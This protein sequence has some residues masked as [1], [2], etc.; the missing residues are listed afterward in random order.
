MGG[1]DWMNEG[2]EYFFKWRPAPTQQELE[3]H[4]KDL[5]GASEIRPVKMQGSLSY[6]VIA[7]VTTETIVSFRVP[8]QKLGGDIDKLARKIHG[9]VVPEATYHGDVGSTE[10]ASTGLLTVCTMPYLPGKSYLEVMSPWPDLDES[11][12][13]KQLNFNR[14][15]ARYF[16]RAWLNPQPVSASKLQEQQDFVLKKLALLEQHS[17]FDYMKPLLARLRGKDGVAKL[18]S[19]TH[20]QVL[21]HKD[22]NPQNLLMDPEDFSITGLIDWSRARIA[23]F[24]ID[25]YAVR[26][27]NGNVNERGWTD[28]KARKALEA[29]FWDEFFATTLVK[30]ST[31]QKAIQATAEM[32]AKLSLILDY[33]FFTTLGGDPIDEV[34]PCPAEYLE[35]WLGADSWHDIILWDE[36]MKTTEKEQEKEKQKKATQG[37]AHADGGEGSDRA[38][39]KTAEEIGNKR[40]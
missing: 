19:S 29:A 3:K 31:E 16:A 22:L 13:K 8:E 6:T 10:E 33:A 20:P 40:S 32:A 39:V 17:M 7:T 9:N 23:P 14:H 1:T 11:Q 24:G 4:A 38:V 34:S 18:Y 30:N 25:F 37:T 36:E 26:R 5:L 12:L 15:L 21:N 27:L 2:I 28:Y 35:W